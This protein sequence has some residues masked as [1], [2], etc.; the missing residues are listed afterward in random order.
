MNIHS[1]AIVD[2]AAEIDASVKID[3]Y[4]VIKGNV[5]IK[6]GTVIGHHASI[7][8][9]TEIGENNKIFQF[10][11]IGSPPQDLKYNNE[12]TK[13]IIGNNNVFREF[14]TINRGTPG[15]LGY[16]K[17]GNNNF[18]MAYS[19]V[20]HDCIVED[21]VVLANNATLAGHILVQKR[22]IIG[23][24]SAVHQFARIGC[25]AMI[26]GKTGIVKDVPPYML[27]SGPRAKLFGPNLIGLERNGFSKEEIHVIK[28]SY[29][30]L[31]R[32][33]N[34]FSEAIELISKEFSDFEV[35]KTLLEFLK[36]SK[37]GITL[38]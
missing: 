5:K 9:P 24:L 30:I 27:A 12:D 8:G 10:A 20:A 35:I 17:I 22:A 38:G 3:A 23:G 37:R 31:F 29:N 14:V 13:L 18:F 26:A 2:S 36:N 1:T 34:K 11:S 21:E 15:G 19:H 25:Y 16:T 32:K 28:K 7:E 6:Q 4:A 33:K